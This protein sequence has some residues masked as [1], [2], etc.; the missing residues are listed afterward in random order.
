M[1]VGIFAYGQKSEACAKDIRRDMMDKYAAKKI[2]L[3]LTCKVRGCDKQR[4]VSSDDHLVYL[5]RMS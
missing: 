2:P 4:E 3:D 5:D 1:Q